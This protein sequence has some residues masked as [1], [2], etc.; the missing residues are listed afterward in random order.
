[1]VLAHQALF[2]LEEPHSLDVAALHRPIELLL[3]KVG[4]TR[5]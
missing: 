5:R 1:L 3:D 4:T 2:Q